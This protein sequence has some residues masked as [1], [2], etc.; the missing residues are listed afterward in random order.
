MARARL[1][2]PPLLRHDESH[3]HHRPVSTSKYP[4]RFGLFTIIVLGEGATGLING[5]AAVPQHTFAS[6]LAAA[7]GLAVV[8]GL[9]WIYFDFVG[10]RR[11][12]ATPGHI[13]AWIY[14]HIGLYVWHQPGSSEAVHGG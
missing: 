2:Q 3:A 12:H 7:S 14:S 8:F 10:R 1:W 4:E 11:I 5:A 6:A 9:W 13:L